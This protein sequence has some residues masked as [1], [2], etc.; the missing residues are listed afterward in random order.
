MTQRKTVNE[1]DPITGRIQTESNTT[2]NVANLAEKTDLSVKED[3]IIFL[4]YL[5]NKVH[6][7]KCFVY[8]NTALAVPANGFYRIRIK[9]GAKRLHFTVDYKT[10]FK[11]RFKTY[12]NPTILTP[13]TLVT[14][15]NR[16]PDSTEVLLTQFY[17]DPTFSGGT[18]R[19]NQFTGASGNV[20][21]RAGGDKSQGL[22]SDFP[23]LTELILELQNVSEVTA[24]LAFIINCYEEE[25]V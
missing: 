21:T 1:I 5:H 24:D 20:Q 18:L 15:F 14:P 8:D 25:T 17:A 6:E 23:A 11:G 10:E 9:T 13:G 19:G 16:K 12:S 2:F 4:E 3:G 22:E 7:G